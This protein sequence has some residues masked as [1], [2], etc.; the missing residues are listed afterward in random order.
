MAYEHRLQLQEQI[1]LG[2]L[3]TFHYFELDRTFTSKE[4]KHDF[5]ELV[6]V[7]KGKVAISTDSG[8]RLLEQGDIIFYKPNEMHS[9]GAREETAPNLIILSFE[10]ESPAMRFFEDRSFRL[11]DGE[12]ALLAHIVEEGLEAFEPSIA[13]RHSNKVLGRRAD[14]AF[15]CEQL[16][17]NYLEVL[18][19]GLIRRAATLDTEWKPSLIGKENRDRHLVAEAIAYMEEHVRH[20]LTLEEISGACSVSKSLLK[21]RFKE[22][23]GMGVMEYFTRIKIDKAKVLIREES[24]NYTQMADLLG[25]SSIHYFSRQFKLITGMT[26]TEYARTVHARVSGSGALKKGR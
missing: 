20:N 17:K 16:I 18:L 10:C 7:D 22:A 3:V 15:G 21:T 1:R 11:N 13:L 14:S 4:E 23:K 5:W 6:Y 24:L 26:L 9:G 12:R 8:K 2:R 25:Y 19:I